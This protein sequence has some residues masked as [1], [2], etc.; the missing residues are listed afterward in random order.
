MSES[1][2]KDDELRDLSIPLAE[3]NLALEMLF[4]TTATVSIYTKGVSEC[5]ACFQ[6]LHKEIENSLGTDRSISEF[7]KGR[8]YVAL[9]LL[10]LLSKIN[11]AATEAL[12]GR[13]APK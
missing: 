1:T 7:D 3:Y 5:F 2:D 11:G 13:S 4:R 10:K 9:E 8:L 12:H 6:H